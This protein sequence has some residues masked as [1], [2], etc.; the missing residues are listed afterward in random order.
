MY[1][2]SEKQ[3]ATAS[4]DRPGTKTAIQPDISLPAKASGN[5]IVAAGAESGAS[6][7]TVG[8]PGTVTFRL[9]QSQL[10]RARGEWHDGRWVVLLTRTLAVESESDGVAL[11][12]GLRVSIAVAVWD[13]SHRDRD[14]KKLITIWQDLVLEK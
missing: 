9:P 6:T 4:F 7:L 2:F 5:P 14:G 11:A 3:V 10:V 1:P 12:P 13:G 8:G